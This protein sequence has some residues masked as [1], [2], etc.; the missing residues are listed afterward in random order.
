METDASSFGIGAVLA[1]K[2]QEPDMFIQ[3][4]A[5]QGP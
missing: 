1:Q 5:H 2:H 3:W 4:L